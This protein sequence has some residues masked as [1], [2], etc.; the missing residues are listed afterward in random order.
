VVHDTFVNYDVLDIVWMEH[1]K[2][3]V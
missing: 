2:A 1:D 3:M